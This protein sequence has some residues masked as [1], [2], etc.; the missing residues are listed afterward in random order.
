[1]SSQPQHDGKPPPWGGFFLFRSSISTSGLQA[2]RS[3][4]TGV[5]AAIAVAQHSPAL[6]DA[7][8]RFVE[9]RRSN[10]NTQIKALS[11]DAL[12]G[13]SGGEPISQAVG[14]MVSLAQA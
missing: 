9:H 5:T 6:N 1:M 7:D 10:M 3:G 4:V 13:I 2:T 11:D 14:L 8:G 12:D